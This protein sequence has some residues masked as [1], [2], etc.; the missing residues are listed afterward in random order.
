MN[1]ETFLL[2]AQEAA[3]FCK[4]NNLI[5][6]REKQSEN[7][8]YPQYLMALEINLREMFLN[9]KPSLNKL[10]M[11][12]GKMTAQEWIEKQPEEWRHIETDAIYECLKSHWSLNAMTIQSVARE[13]DALKNPK[14]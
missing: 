8:F 4:D 3:I 11:S 10:V 12:N 6:F 5:T 2:K 7:P 13:L 9:Q 1:K 14:D